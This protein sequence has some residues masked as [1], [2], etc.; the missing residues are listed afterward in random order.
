MSSVE[1]LIPIL[2]IAVVLIG[3]VYWRSK[4]EEKRASAPGMG[5]LRSI[6]TEDPLVE[7]AARVEPGLVSAASIE[8]AAAQAAAAAEGEVDR[9]PA[10]AAA[11]E[12]SAEPPVYDVLEREEAERK[13]AEAA[14]KEEEPEDEEEESPKAAAARETPPVDPALEWLLD[15]APVEGMQFALGGVKSLKLELEGLGLAL[16]VHV[17]AQSSKDGLYYE[18]DELTGPARHV[19]AA[20]ALANR[21]AHLDEVSA[22]RFFQVLEQSAAQNGV[23]IRRELEPVQAV[24]RSEGLK[25]FIDYFDR[26]IEVLITPTDPETSFDF[27]VVDHA[28]KA[29]GFTAAS[30]RWEMKLDPAERDPVFTLSFGTDGTQ[31]L[32]LAYDLP[33]GSLSRGDLK[34]FFALANDLAARLDGLWSDCSRRPIDAGGAMMIAETVAEHARLM[35]EKG[36]PPGSPRAQLLFSH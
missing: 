9:E 29:A 3:L 10:S 25:H 35:T 36:V 28:A 5:S 15:I 8:K 13:A 27:D 16:A 30:G 21:A 23:P 20:L 11:G 7:S 26:R 33:L 4:R 6:K 12:P 22:S 32:V 31:T 18:S 24:Q 34:R 19:V 17:F 1:I 2:V 14:E